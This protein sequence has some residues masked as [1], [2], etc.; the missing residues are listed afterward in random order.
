MGGGTGNIRTRRSQSGTN[1]SRTLCS[2]LSSDSGAGAGSVRRVY[3]WY[4]RN[5]DTNTFYNSVF[6]I[7]YGQYKDRTQW[8]LSS[9]F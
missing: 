7:K 9:V 5:G 2:I 3:G 4:A 8:F 6:D 1:G